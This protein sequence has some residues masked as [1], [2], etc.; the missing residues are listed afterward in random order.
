MIVKWSSGKVQ[1]ISQVRVTSQK[2]SELDIGGRETVMLLLFFFL[3]V[4]VNY[5][6]SPRSLRH[7]IALYH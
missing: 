2:F 3:K 1:V 5:S 6:L 7:C 4:H